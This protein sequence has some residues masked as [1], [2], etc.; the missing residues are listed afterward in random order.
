MK[1]RTGKTIGV[2]AGVAAL[3]LAV[4]LAVTAQAQPSDDEKTVVVEIPDPQGPECGAFKETLPNWK[5]LSD[6]P[7]GTALGRIP[8]VSTFY[9]AISGGLNP[10]VN[11]VPVLD[12]GPYVVFAPSNEAF[13]ALAPGQLEYLRTD[14]AALTDLVYYHA[15]LGLLGPDDV[16]GQRP[17]QQ[18]AEVGVTG[19]GGDIKV[20]ETAEVTCGGIQAQ[21]ARIYIVDQVLDPADAPEP[22]APT[23]TST[24]ATTTPS[25][26]PTGTTEP[27]PPVEVPDAGTGAAEAGAAEAGAAEAPAG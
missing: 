2:A 20:N 23:S 6:L 18:G 10:A 13:A 4:P 15:F 25:T 12:N 5:E 1:S 17:T 24:S 26:S 8:E 27:A 22:I 11:I 21:N 16:K 3:A 7:V 19:K 14:A 9:S